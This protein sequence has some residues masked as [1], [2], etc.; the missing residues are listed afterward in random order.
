M[1][2]VVALGGPLPNRFAANAAT[3]P[4]KAGVSR[5]SGNK[6]PLDRVLKKEGGHKLA[7][8]PA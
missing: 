3:N 5:D 8:D 2:S 6:P 1:A 4:G 7:H